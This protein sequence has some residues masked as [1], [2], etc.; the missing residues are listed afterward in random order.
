[1][2]KKTNNPQMKGFEELYEKYLTQDEEY[3]HNMQ[4]ENNRN[5]DLYEL[6]KFLEEENARI[7]SLESFLTKKIPA[8]INFPQS[9]ILITH[10]LERKNEILE[11][12]IPVL[13]KGTSIFQSNMA[14]I[15]NGHFS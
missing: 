4:K 12:L 11:K 9:G 7:A 3:A 5:L 6:Q 13:S 8:K 10:Q 14:E 15:F 1:M 2:N